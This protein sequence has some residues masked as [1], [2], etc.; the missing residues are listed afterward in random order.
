MGIS[1]RN[2]RTKINVVCP[3]FFHQC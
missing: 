3:H 1:P 2:P